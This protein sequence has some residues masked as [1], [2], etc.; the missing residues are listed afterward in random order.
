MLCRAMARSSR[1]TGAK[2]EFP[3]SLP[4]REMSF[5]HFI[6]GAMRTRW[7]ITLVVLVAVIA[8]GLVF[9]RIWEEPTYQ[10]KPLSVWLD[11]WAAIYQPCEV[12][13]L[14][15]GKKP[16]SRPKRKRG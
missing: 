6:L 1:R 13:V 4:N 16:T 8:A 12:R 3:R 11:E 2:A 10:G 14:P 9:R 7:K 15:A 5:A